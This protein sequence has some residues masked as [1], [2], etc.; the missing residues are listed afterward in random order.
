ML[1]VTR[2]AKFPEKALHEESSKPA[3]CSASASESISSLVNSEKELPPC[4]QK[5]KASTPTLT[6]TARL[7]ITKRRKRRW[8]TDIHIAVKRKHH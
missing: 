4:G 8:L 7:Y 5:E 2:N 1:G 6:K 3:G